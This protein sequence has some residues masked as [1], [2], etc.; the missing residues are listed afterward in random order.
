MISSMLSVNKENLAAITFE[1]HQ[2]KPDTM[3]ITLFFF[4]T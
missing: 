2:W 3:L 1:K 4:F